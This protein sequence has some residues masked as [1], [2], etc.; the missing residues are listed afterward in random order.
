MRP[1]REFRNIDIYK[2]SEL[3]YIIIVNNILTE[4]ASGNKKKKHIV[5]T[6]IITDVAVA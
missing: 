6:V 1:K 2:L 5:C 4:I 3:C